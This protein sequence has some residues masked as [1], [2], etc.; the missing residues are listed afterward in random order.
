[1]E[2]FENVSSTRRSE[3]AENASKNKRSAIT[4]TLSSQVSITIWP[5]SSAYESVDNMD[6][7]WEEEEYNVWFSEQ[8]AKGSP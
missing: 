8:V 6:E 2:T 7:E 1:M 3:G 4:V 5:R